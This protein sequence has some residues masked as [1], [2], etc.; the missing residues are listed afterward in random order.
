MDCEADKKQADLL[1]LLF[2]LYD[3]YFVVQD[4]A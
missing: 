1:L 3:K 2:F 4:C